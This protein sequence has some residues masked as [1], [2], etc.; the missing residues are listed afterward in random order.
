MLTAASLR[1]NVKGFEALGIGRGAATLYAFGEKTTKGNR[2]D[3]ENCRLIEPHEVGH[4]WR[5]PLAYVIFTSGSTGRS[6]GV[7]ITHSNFCP[8]MHWGYD[9]MGIGPGDRV[10]QNLSYYFDWSVWE[11]FIALTSGASLHMVE[12]E[13]MLDAGAYIEFINRQKITALHITPTQFQ[14]LTGT[15]ERFSSLKHL[16][17]GAEKLT[18][19]LVQRAYST[20]ET[21]GGCRVYNMYGPTEATIMSAVLDLDI[22]KQD[23]YK[24]LSSIPIG[25]PI[26]NAGLYILDKNLIPTPTNIPGELFI[27]GDGLALGYLNNPELTS[28]KFT[29]CSGTLYA[30]GEK[31]TKGNRQD[32]N[33][34]PAAK[35]LRGCTRRVLYKTG[36]LARF[37][38]DG[39]VEFLGRIDFQVKIR[40]F[41]IELGEIEN[42]LLEHEAVKEVTVID[43]ERPDG[44]KYLCAYIVLEAPGGG[45]LLTEKENLPASLREYLAAELPGYMV[46][47]YFVFLE[48]MP[49][50]PNK[51]IDRKALPEPA[52]IGDNTEYIAPRDEIEKKLTFL[53]S[54][55]L[56][57]PQEQIGINSDFFACGGHSLKATQ[58]TANIHK[59]F[60][61]NISLADIFSGSTVREIAGVIKKASVEEFQPIE[62][63]PE[64]E[65]YELSPA[66]RRIYF[67][68][69][70]TSD[71]TVYN[72]PSAMF[73]EGDVNPGKIQQVFIQLIARHESLRTSFH[74]IDGQAVQRVCQP[75]EIDFEINEIRKHGPTD[76]TDLHRLK[77]ENAIKPHAVGPFDL[78]RA[79]LMR[80]SLVK[81]E[82]ER[83]LL[84]IDMHHIISDGSSMAILT[85]EFL[86]L[87]DGRDLAPLN[88]QYKDYAN[89]QINRQNSGKMQVQEAYWLDK[90]S[91]EVPVLH[92]PLDFTRPGQQDF[93][94]G[95]YR[96]TFE[97]EIVRGLE[98]LAKQEGLTLYMLLFGLFD[99]LLAKLGGQEDIVAGTVT[100]GRMQPGTGDIV[101]MFVNTLAMRFFPCGDKP[102]KAFLQEVKEEVLNSRDNQDYPFEELVEKL[103][104]GRESGRNPLFDVMFVFQDV[105]KPVAGT[106]S[107]K[108][109][110]IP[111]DTGVSKFDM[112]FACEESGQNLE[113]TVE[114]AL[115]LFKSGTIETFARYFRDIAASIVKNPGAKI[116]EVDILSGGERDLIMEEFNH[117]PPQYPEQAVAEIFEQQVEETPH[118]IAAYSKGEY[119]DYKELDRRAGVLAEM[120]KRACNR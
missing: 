75:G 77:D 31:T 43:R 106:S 45:T 87:Y 13:V 90:F 30:F 14:S 110:P 97:K 47:S 58:L 120:I 39:T 22:S 95:V 10:V 72:M 1:E 81:Q 2:Q 100:A 61:V 113:F 88:L 50:N 34:V 80:V 25:P 63:V 28:E 15:G 109:F 67:A 27:S 117:V 38:D 86:S 36:D 108:V 84:M 74:I 11:I 18:L 40:G 37:L 105:F 64:K 92:L 69:Q 96:F 6:K 33:G 118:R 83:Y 55:L 54:D 53:F 73:L 89:W 9:H 59:T 46:P 56:A 44:E 20:V 7:A 26:A 85:R 98:D 65:Y 76:Y 24:R 35:P 8:L 21:A 112:T 49:L 3:L 41:R 29:R 111:P 114:Y 93:S 99:I 91:G 16:A 107:L 104:L 79:P 48:Q 12:E 70:M 52:G 42:R 5:T 4:S 116:A 66:Q 115:K 101:G 60:D 19:D 103:A 82:E 51:K 32:L 71:S 78:S 119:L 23:F 62:R 102:I 94:G 57:I 68:Q 17:I